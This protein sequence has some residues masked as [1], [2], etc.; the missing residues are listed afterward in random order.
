MNCG[1]NLSANCDN[2][3]LKDLKVSPATLDLRACLKSSTHP[4]PISPLGSDLL[5]NRGRSKHRHAT[6]GMPPS[7]ERRESHAINRRRLLVNL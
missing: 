1:S 3:K 6:D 5:V 7:L 2:R 4:K